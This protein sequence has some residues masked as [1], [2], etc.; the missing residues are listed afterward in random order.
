MDRMNQCDEE[1]TIVLLA[2][3]HLEATVQTFV[4]LAA[5]AAAL[6]GPESTYSENGD[7]SVRPTDTHSRL[8]KAMLSGHPFI[9][10]SQTVFTVVS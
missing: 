5:Q 9:F 1:L 3:L 7:Y 4:N 10:K 8:L 2:V 6:K